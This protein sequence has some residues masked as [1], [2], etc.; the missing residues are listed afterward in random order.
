MSSG[1]EN[2]WESAIDEPPNRGSFS[3]SS[4]APTACVTRE[5][6]HCPFCDHELSYVSKTKDA[7]ELAA[8]S[9]IARQHKGENVIVILPDA[10]DAATAHPPQRESF[11][12]GR[13]D[14]PKQR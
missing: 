14:S 13:E 1:D 5:V 6:W 9:H 12:P 11:P 3:F 4:A 8:N 7:A 2:C 10:G